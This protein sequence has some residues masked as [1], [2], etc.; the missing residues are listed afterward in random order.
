MKLIYKLLFISK[1][2]IDYFFFFDK[3]K[4][5]LFIKFYLRLNY[6]V[7]EK[8]SP[9]LIRKFIECFFI[10]AEMHTKQKKLYCDLLFDGK[11]Q[12]KNQVIFNNKIT[13][14]QK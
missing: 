4:N 7:I 11:I 5:N 12:Y 14:G 8:T 3:N 10:I 13:C 9:L 6:D 2:K 1:Y